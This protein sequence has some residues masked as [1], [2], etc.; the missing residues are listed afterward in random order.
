MRI[1]RPIRIFAAFIYALQMVCIIFSRSLLRVTLLVY[2]FVFLLF[3]ILYTSVTVYAPAIALS[4][5]KNKKFDKLNHLYITEYRN[6]VR[7]RPFLCR[8]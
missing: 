7:L 2:K 3:Q 6:V 4:H 8:V 1:N 5:G